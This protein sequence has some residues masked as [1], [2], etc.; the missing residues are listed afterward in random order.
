MSSGL[1]AANVKDDEVVIATKW[2]P[3]MRW[4]GSIKKTIGKPTIEDF[5]Y[6]KKVELWG[7][8]SAILGYSIAWIFPFN[9]LAAFLISIGKYVTRAGNGGV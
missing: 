7:R 3:M 6:L 9:I 2:L 1:Q 4:A 5:K 8:V